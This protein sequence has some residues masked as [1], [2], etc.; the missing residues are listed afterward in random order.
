LDELDAGAGAKVGRVKF[1]TIYHPNYAKEVAQHL[2][3]GACSSELGQLLIDDLAG[4]NE[5]N[6][7]EGDFATSIEQLGPGEL[8]EPARQAVAASMR[9]LGA[10]TLA[11][12][13]MLQGFA[14]LEP[15]DD[16]LVNGLAQDPTL[17]SELEALMCSWCER[18]ELEKELR[19]LDSYEEEEV[20]KPERK[21]EIIQAEA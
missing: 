17:A 12:L 16:E 15:L 11:E 5:D 4:W 21:P 6:D 1:R 9:R 13:V 18:H 10:A 20:I 14:E 7:Y 19:T 8:D 2:E 3:G